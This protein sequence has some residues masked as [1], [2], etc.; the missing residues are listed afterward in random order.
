MG[1]TKKERL[2]ENRRRKSDRN[3]ENVRYSEETKLGNHTSVKEGPVLFLMRIYPF[4]ELYQGL[5]CT[6]ATMNKGQYPLSYLMKI[7]ENNQMDN[8]KWLCSGNCLASF[9]ISG[10]RGKC[11]FCVAEKLVTNY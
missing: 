10:Y 4:E 3:T 11:Y 5:K 8:E 7:I 9:L 1:L 6:C 2:L